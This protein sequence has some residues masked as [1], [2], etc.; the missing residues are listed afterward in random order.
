MEGYSYTSTHPLGHTGP[1]K[2]SLYLFIERKKIC[3]VYLRYTNNS[4]KTSAKI[5]FA[6]T[7]NIF[8]AVLLYWRLTE[9]YK[10]LSLYS[11]YEVYVYADRY[12]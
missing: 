8:Q 9:R 6:L 12:T 3:I 1:V 4:I 11:I 5:L 2:G 10:G 7:K